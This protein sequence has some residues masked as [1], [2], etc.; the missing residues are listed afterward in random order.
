MTECKVVLD[1]ISSASFNTRSRRKSNLTLDNVAELDSP[2]KGK[3]SKVSESVASDDTSLSRTRVS[4][5]LSATQN[6]PKKEAKTTTTRAGAATPTR[7]NSRLVESIDLTSSPAVIP[8]KRALRSNSV[9]SEDL[10]PAS[11]STRRSTR[12]SRLAESQG[13]PNKAK[14]ESES[15]MTPGRK[16]RVSRLL[17]RQVQ[18]IKEEEE[19][20]ETV[21]IIELNDDTSQSSPKP[22]SKKRSTST[23]ETQPS[24]GKKHAS[25]KK[26]VTETVDTMES[27]GKVLL[28]QTS[29]AN[30]NPL[31]ESR[32]NVVQS[33][34]LEP[35]KEEKESN[36]NITETVAPSHDLNAVV[37]ISVVGKN[38]TPIAS[39]Q[40]D[41]ALP[42]EKSS[43]ENKMAENVKNDAIIVDESTL[44]HQEVDPINVNSS[45]SGEPEIPRPH[46]ETSMESVLVID[47]SADDTPIKGSKI[48]ESSSASKKKT[49]LTKSPQADLGLMFQ[50]TTNESLLSSKLDLKPNQTKESSVSGTDQS[51]Q[52]KNSQTPKK[53]STKPK[54]PSKNDL[55]LMNVTEL[56][57]SPKPDASVIELPSNQSK[58]PKGKMPSK[59]ISEFADMDVT[60]IN[61]PSTSIIGKAAVNE[62]LTPKQK[63][64][65]TESANILDSMNV[66]ELVNS[67]KPKKDIQETVA[68][69][70]QSPKPK[71]PEKKSQIA[72]SV[73][74]L[75]LMNVTELV[76]SPKP[77]TPEQKV[78]TAEPTNTL[79]LMNVTELVN[80][81]KPKQRNEV[82]VIEKQSLKP[83]T[84]S[85]SATESGDNAIEIET[86]KKVSSKQNSPK[87]TPVS[88]KIATPKNKTTKAKTPWK[89]LN[90]FGDMNV[91]K[92]VEEITVKTATPKK[93]EENVSAPVADTVAQNIESD[94]MEGANNQIVKSPSSTKKT[95]TPKKSPLTSAL[96][97]QSINLNLEI[98]KIYESLQ[99]PNEMMEPKKP[100][101][102]AIPVDDG[103]ILDDTVE[104]MDVD[105]T[106]IGNITSTSIGEQPDNQLDADDNNVSSVSVSSRKSVQIMTPKVTKNTSG[107][108]RLGTPYPDKKAFDS[109]LAREEEIKNSTARFM[110]MFCILFFPI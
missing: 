96:A 62:A 64:Q 2:A 49:P 97:D 39:L 93:A 16:G 104:P 37:N 82:A 98:S 91:T 53:D 55:S 65:T 45:D 84:P 80:S 100:D 67:P 4:S 66:T 110:G 13:T 3:R 69:E 58:S 41:Q 17:T 88:D 83:K 28:V 109:A 36:D 61:S 32:E 106:Q 22:K 46:L 44:D 63:S 94:M 24:N 71:T 77:K 99:S 101:I 26:M 70:K 12:S 29:T 19:E 73:N 76:N 34:N 43:V 52:V 89:D 92:L 60:N 33:A 56:I 27:T 6:T 38:L 42:N 9:A 14:V 30:L 103:N 86:P 50:S 15:V 20:I 48:I 108:N 54:T 78:Q 85:K 1:R 51:M 95:T 7:R 59:Y 57:N 10:P 107:L 68:I 8:A 74:A 31:D 21:S 11:P 40:S 105:Q 81:P 79:D 102:F 35:V 23:P 47:E 18:E 90:E 75:D 87:S 25:S 72:D 5:R